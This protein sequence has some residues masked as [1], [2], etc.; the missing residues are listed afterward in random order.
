MKESTKKILRGIACRLESAARLTRVPSR[1]FCLLVCG[2]LAFNASCAET[3]DTP[4]S[5]FRIRQDKDVLHVEPA[6]HDGSGQTKA[7]RYFD[8]IKE[9]GIVFRKRALSKGG[10]IGMHVLGHDEVYYVLSGQAEFTVDE[11]QRALQPS[12]AVYMSKGAN[13]GIRQTGEDDLVLIVAYP[14]PK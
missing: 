2:T 14:A 7:Y 6:P 1:L 8:D 12:T 5:K 3:P 10:A 13:V 11:V 9:A 4:N